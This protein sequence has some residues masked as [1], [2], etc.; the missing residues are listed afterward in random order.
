MQSHHHHCLHSSDH[1][2]CE[3][4][5]AGCP[6]SLFLHLFQKWT[7]YDTWLRFL[8]GWVPFLSSSQQCQIS[9]GNGAY[10]LPLFG[11]KCQ[12]IELFVYLLIYWNCSQV[13]C[14]VCSDF[15]APLM[16]RD[17]RP[18]RVCLECFNILVAGARQ[19][20]TVVFLQICQ[21]L[22]LLH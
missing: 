1:F 16:Y 17:Y 12:F 13:V 22:W 7:V 18:E 4:G 2:R 5:F 19:F 11:T 9:E 3:R 10:N 21:R 6:V 14:H 8:M 20:T 15:R